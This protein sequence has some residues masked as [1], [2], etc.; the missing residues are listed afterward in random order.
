MTYRE[1][2]DTYATSRDKLLNGIPVRF[3]NVQNKQQGEKLPVAG[4]I[5]SIV[6]IQTSRALDELPGPIES[7]KD[8]P[9]SILVE[10]IEFNFRGFEAHNASLDTYDPSVNYCP[11]L[12]DA[13]DSNGTFIVEFKR[14][15]EENAMLN[16]EVDWFDIISPESIH[17]AEEDEIKS[18]KQKNCETVNALRK[19]IVD[20]L[21]SLD[22]ADPG[23]S[24]LMDFASKTDDK[25]L[26]LIDR[27]Y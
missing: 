16:D 6:F 7:W 17:I 12:V 9:A 2:L 21:S 5:A 19:H 14:T 1:L 25:L 10:A 8:A 22:K 15:F 24:V 20:T 27:L 3:K 23:F 4:M 26:N 18:A 11:W 13:C